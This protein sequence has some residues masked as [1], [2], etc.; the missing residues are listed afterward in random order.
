M[1]ETH[2]LGQVTQKALI[3]HEGKFLLL[4]YP[5]HHPEAG[6]FWDMPG[7]RLNEEEE[8]LE[9]LKREVREEIGVEI[10]IGKPLATAVFTN[11]SHKKNFLVLYSARLVDP[12]LELR[13]DPEE[14]GG[15]AWLTREEIIAPDFPIY[16]R[17]H[18]RVV[19]DFL[20]AKAV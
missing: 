2:Y 10:E 8:P 9:G 16:Y 14:T 5:E 6:G 4:R 12:S 11:L 7:G 15:G 18:K 20:R 1:P 13:F 19:Q 3:E 17:E